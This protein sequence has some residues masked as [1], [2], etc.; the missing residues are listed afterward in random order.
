MKM[1]KSVLMV[2]TLFALSTLMAAFAFSSATIKN[3]GSLTVTSTN[4][5]LLALIP[6]TGVGNLD[7]AAFVKDGALKID[8]AKGY[9]GNFGVQGNS[10]YKWDSL[11][12]VKNNSNE[13]VQFN[14]TKE[15]WGFDTKANIYLGAKNDST[16]ATAEFYSRS[17]SK[18]GKITLAPGQT[19]TVY[20]NV[21]TESK[22]QM[23]V[24]NATLTVN[25]TAIN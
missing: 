15:G 2:V 12:Q 6:G 19:A 8:L 1:K 14:I 4:E 18:N 7:G 24:R 25:A 10:T 11:F 5:S 3:D 17:N 9:N 13:T 20:L 21:E 22:A 16:G 23:T